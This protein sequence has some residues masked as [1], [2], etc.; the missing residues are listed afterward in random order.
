MQKRDVLGA[1]SGADLF[2][3]RQVQHGATQ[4]RHGDDMAQFRCLGAQQLCQRPRLGDG[5]QQGRARIGENARVAAQ[6]FLDLRGAQRRIDRHR[7]GAGQEYSV[8]AEKVLAARGQH[9]RHRL[10][11]LHIVRAQ[12]R[13]HVAGAR[14]ERRIAEGFFLFVAASE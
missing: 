10:A 8:E 4:L 2:Q 12:A 11:R 6:V 7:D 13:G 1:D 14:L 3:L 5:D 9:D